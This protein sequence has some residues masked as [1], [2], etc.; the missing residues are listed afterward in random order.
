MDTQSNTSTNKALQEALSP[1]VNNIIEENYESTKEQMSAHLAPLMG[2]AIR[3]QIKSQKDDVVDALY[4]VIGN[5][6]SRYVTKSLEEM[7]KNINA[8]IQNGLSSTS[9]KRK[10][11]AK[12]KGVSETQL[13]LSENANSSVRAVFLIH[14][15][16]GIVL[17]QAQNPNYTLHEPE[18]MASMMTAIRSFVN[19]CISQE[20]EAQELGEIEYSGNKIILEAS[21]HSY[22]AIMVEGASYQTTYEKIRTVFGEI[23]SQHSDKIREFNGDL[24][25][26]ATLHIDNTLET[27][28]LNDVQ[29]EEKQGIHPLMYIIPLLLLTWGIF[30]FYTSYQNEELSKKTS[31]KLYNTPEL[32]LY[33]LTT[34]VTDSIVTIE[35]AVPFSFHKHLATKLLQNTKGVKEVHNNIIIIPTLSDPLQISTH[36][37]YILQG[38]NIQKG[39]SLRYEYDYQNLTLLGHTQTIRQKRKVLESL[40]QIKGLS[41]ISNQIVVKPPLLNKSIYF[42]RGDTSISSQ[43]QAKLIEIIERVHL[44][45]TNLSIVLNSFSDLIGNVQKNNRLAQKRMQNIVIFLQT[46]GKL[47]NKFIIYNTNHAPKDID[48]KKEPQKAR[49]VTITYNKGKNDSL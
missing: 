21:N 18:M 2:S 33:R 23:L 36:I 38:F 44:S 11:K 4:P 10:I 22:L 9:L 46:Q 42:Q 13:L 1:L 37:A 8:Q 31:A 24:E 29:E 12:I 49:C 45:D 47:T 28:L 16:T 3:E 34:R 30:H 6:I 20:D 27:L 7:L 41:A 15:D 5:M 40:Q 39:V 43:E 35:G 48:P 17:S 32:T 26:F 25:E 19:D 14:K